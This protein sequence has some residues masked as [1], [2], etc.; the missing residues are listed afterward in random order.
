MDLCDWLTKENHCFRTGQS[1]MG[2]GV[3]SLVGL[4]LS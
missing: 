1:M 3:L 4:L 2:L